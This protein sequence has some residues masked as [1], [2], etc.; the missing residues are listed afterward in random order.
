MNYNDILGIF[1]L[2]IYLLLNWLKFEIK[3]KKIEEELF[4]F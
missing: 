4:F 2:F 1:S 3:K